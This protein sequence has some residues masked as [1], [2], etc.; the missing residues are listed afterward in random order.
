M[1]RVASSLAFYPYRCWECENRFYLR[2]PDGTSHR[3]GRPA[4]RGTPITRKLRII[5]FCSA[6]LI[7]VGLLYFIAHRAR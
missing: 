3:G 2:L 7:L 1:D 5:A 4:A 6:V